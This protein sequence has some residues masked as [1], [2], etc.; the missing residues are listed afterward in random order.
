MLEIVNDTVDLSI[1]KLISE[2]E[3]MTL[4]EIAEK[5]GK[6]RI[7]VIRRI[8]KL[9]IKGIIERFDSDKNRWLPD[10]VIIP[11]CPLGELYGCTAR[12]F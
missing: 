8:D 12:I 6:T 9:K 11:K 7:T 2:N 5:T 10:K 4:N 3:R 1:I